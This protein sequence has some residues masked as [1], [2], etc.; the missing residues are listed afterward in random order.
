MDPFYESED[1]EFESLRARQIP[2]IALYDA[3]SPPNARCALENGP[4]LRA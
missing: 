1:Q 2:P 4:R 3:L